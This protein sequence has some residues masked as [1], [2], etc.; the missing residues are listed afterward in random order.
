MDPIKAW[1]ELQ[2]KLVRG[3]DREGIATLADALIVWLERG[4]FMPLAMATRYELR[5]R[6]ISALV[7]VHLAAI[8]E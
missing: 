8:A 2:H 4:G 6:A 3:E 1:D 7:D 5:W